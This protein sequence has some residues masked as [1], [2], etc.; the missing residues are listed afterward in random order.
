MV[1]TADSDEPVKFISVGQDDFDNDRNEEKIDYLIKL[2][3]RIELSKAYRF[4]KDLAKF[5][6]EWS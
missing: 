2:L 5:I 6:T 1:K 3:V 4:K